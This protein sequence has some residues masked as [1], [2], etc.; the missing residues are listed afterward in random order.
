MGAATLSERHN[1][2]SAMVSQH[3][4][5]LLAAGHGPLATA[6]EAH[7]RSNQVVSAVELLY[8]CCVLQRCNLLLCSMAA[9]TV[10]SSACCIC[11]MTT[12]H[13]SINRYRGSDSIEEP[14]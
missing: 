3:S 10:Q 2:V 12:Q 4:A 1:A 5:Q 9:L 11:T 7:V 14:S 8:E 13:C 6:W